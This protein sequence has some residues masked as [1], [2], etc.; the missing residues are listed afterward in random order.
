MG[1][2]K[3]KSK[4]CEP[5]EGATEGCVSDS[6]VYLA[7]RYGNSIVSFFFLDLQ[8]FC[9]PIAFLEH[10]EFFFILENLLF[11]LCR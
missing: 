5:V 2:C 6:V 8:F 10:V 7:A 1:G 4:Q 3:S 9:G 11:S